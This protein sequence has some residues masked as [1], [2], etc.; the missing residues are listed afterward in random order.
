MSVGIDE[1]PVK[2]HVRDRVSAANVPP[3]GEKVGGGSFAFVV[4]VW[5]AT[6]ELAQP[7]WFTVTA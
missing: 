1:P 5:L 6:S 3:F 2:L 7:T 4:N